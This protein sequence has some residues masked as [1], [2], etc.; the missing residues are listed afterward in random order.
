MKIST[1]QLAAFQA[2]V[3]AGKFSIAAKAIHL[4]QSALSQRIMNLEQDLGVTLLI[5]T[6]NGAH[7]TQAGE[8]L[9]RYCETMN[10]L[11]DELAQD[12]HLPNQRELAGTIKI[13]S[14][15]SVL[16]SVLIPAL[17]DLMKQHPKIHCELICAQVNQLPVLLNRS[18]VDFI[19][20]DQRIDRAHLVAHIIGQEKYVVI[21]SARGTDRQNHYLDNEPSDRT[22]E[23]YFKTQGNLQ[24]PYQRSFFNDCYGII[25]GVKQ[26]LGRAVMSEHLIQ[27]NTSIKIIKK[28][29]PQV[30]PVVLHYHVQ[31]IYSKLHQ[32]VVSTLHKTLLA[33]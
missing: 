8:R 25:D 24:K 28:F 15:S 3:K 10:A 31:P 9:L 29:T 16:R 19:V 18:E 6:P 7:P 27:N 32:K 1:T 22:T 17:S 13:A 26:G 5:R 30:V 11:E 23:V 4:T 2:I 21:E 33:N 14:Y 20:T 12:L